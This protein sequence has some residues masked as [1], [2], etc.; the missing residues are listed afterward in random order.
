MCVLPGGLA[1]VDEAVVWVAPVSVDG[2]GL[3]TKWITL[4]WI[5]IIIQTLGIITNLSSLKHSKQNIPVHW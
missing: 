1:S 4:P 3:W 5:S 2:G